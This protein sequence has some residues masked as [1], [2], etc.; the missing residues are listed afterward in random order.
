[1]RMRRKKEEME[2]GKTWKENDSGNNIGRNKR[3]RQQQ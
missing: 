2:K 1:M 3:D